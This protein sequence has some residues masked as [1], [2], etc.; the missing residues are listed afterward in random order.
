MVRVPSGSG[1]VEW[2][3]LD[4]GAPEPRSADRTSAVGGTIVCVHG[5]PTWGYIW[6]DV[7]T[8]LHRR[9]RVIAVDQTGMGWSQRTGERR[10]AER[11]DELVAF[12]EQE[13]PGP[14]ILVAHDWGGPVAMGAAARLD[15]RAVILANTAVAKPAE[16]AVPPLIAVA[17]SAVGLTC[18]STPVFVRG[19]S[20]MTHR[21]HREPLNAPYRGS[22]RRRAVATF[23]ADIP[24]RPGDRS[25][26]ALRAAADA[27]GDLARRGVPVL[28][29]WGGRDPVF[30]DRFLADLLR[31]APHAQV[32][33]LPEAGH[34]VALDEPIGS[35]IERWLDADHAIHDPHDLGSRQDPGTESSV[36]THPFVPITAA[37]ES[38]RTETTAAYT[39]PDGTRSWGQLAT[40]STRI[41]GHLIDAGVRPGD[42]IAMLVPPGAA[43]LEAAFAVWSVG[44]II[45]VADSALGPS[46]LRRALRAATVDRVIGTPRTILAARALRLAPGAGALSMGR[47]PGTTDLL[48]PRSDGTVDLPSLGP[49]DLAAIVHTSGATGVA[50]PVLYDHGGLAAQRD[51][52]RRSFG[53]DGERGFISSFAPFILL[54]PALGVPCVLPEGDIL[55]PSELDFDAC[56]EACR[57]SGADV[58]WLSP[59]SA[60]TIIRTAAGRRLPLRLVM[61]AGAPIPSGL[62]AEIATITGADVR[63]PYGMTEVMPVT[64]GRGATA[65]LALG[66][67]TGAPLPGA[68][69]MIVPFDDPTG[70]A[71]RAGDWGEILVGA[72]WMRVGY[73][74]RWD[75]DRVALVERQGMTLHRTGDVGLIDD[76]GHL[77]Q[78]GRHQHVITTAD[79][80][81]PCVMVEQPLVESLGRDIA[82]VGVGPA[83]SQVIVVIVSGEGALRLAEQSTTAVVRHSSAIRIAAVLEGQLPVDIRH[84]SKVRRDLLADEA[85]RLLEGR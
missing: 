60:R 74:R 53:L 58:A 30:H 7:L 50:K 52:V 1:S 85:D 47:L 22:R 26:P 49:S 62:A 31:R 13:A 4:T 70:P 80:P 25:A 61:L 69:V 83:G 23:V 40:A 55:T 11:I 72:P 16:V 79:G 3:V 78:L 65:R 76:S 32:H 68:T 33:R 28:L 84:Q 41:A 24:V 19:T 77:I 5:N 17:R 14:I 37:L 59:A 6:R 64:D 8:T 63:A 29:V 43:L 18:E 66:T 42:R 21:S 9:W 81:I 45:V 75:L 67:D 36:G 10:L 46:G 44:A 12:C 39:G 27:F 54:G 48:A 73:D 2:S 71:R 34:L 57:S 82:A 35:I 38:R 20:H 51:V 15:V 56:A